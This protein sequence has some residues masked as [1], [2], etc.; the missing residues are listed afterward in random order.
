MLNKE[1]LRKFRTDFWTE[2]DLHNKKRRTANN[3]K[4]HWAQ[5]KSGIKDIYFRLDFTTHEAFFAID[6]QMRDSSVRELVWDQFM[7]TK[8]ILSKYI[9]DEFELQPNLQIEEGFQIHRLKWTLSGV[10]IANQS[11]YP[12]VLAFLSLKIHGLDAFWFE[13][14]DLFNALCC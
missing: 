7:E 14:S 2:F 9:G 11:D 13:F 12:K 5:Y 1:D 8:T 6:L 4:I 3:R 10:N